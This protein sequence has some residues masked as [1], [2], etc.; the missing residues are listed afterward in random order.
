ML[1]PLLIV[2]ALFAGAIV[3][4]KALWPTNSRPS[5]GNRALDILDERYAQGEIDRE[6]YQRR[7]G[8]ILAR[9]G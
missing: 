3:L 2:I 6:E 8:D 9:R 4:L 7:R 5:S 1:G